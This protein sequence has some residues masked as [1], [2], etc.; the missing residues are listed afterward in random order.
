MA[1]SKRR[2]LAVN[3]EFVML[4]A[5]IDAPAHDGFG[6]SVHGSLALP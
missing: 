4:T 6:A 5:P 2:H 1:P 3:D